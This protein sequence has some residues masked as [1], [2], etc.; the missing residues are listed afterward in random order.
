MGAFPT[1]VAPP[2]FSLSAQ[3]S[4]RIRIR[5]REMI[6]ALTST[7]APFATALEPS[8]WVYHVNPGNDTVF[9]W[10]S[11]VSLA[12][13]KYRVNDLSVE[14]I[15][16][17]AVT[18]SNTIMISPEYDVNDPPATSIIRAAPN[19]D[20]VQGAT[21]SALRCHFS[22]IDHRRLYF[23]RGGTELT[24]QDPKEY[25][26][27]NFTIMYAGANGF[28][29]YVYI[30]YDIELMI[31]NNDL[32][33]SGVCTLTAGGVP[34]V[35]PA[36]MGFG[37]ILKDALPGILSVVGASPCHVHHLPKALNIVSANTIAAE[38][39]C[40]VQDLGAIGAFGHVWQVVPSLR[41]AAEMVFS[42]AA[43]ALGNQLSVYDLDMHSWL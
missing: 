43:G 5:H 18:T 10:L 14:Y 31:P 28:V 17:Q 11:R 24:G 15:P 39:G 19:Q 37:S 4:N 42:V 7:I 30:N 20:T 3:S 13:D 32:D 12:Y 1:G 2:N 33:A 29:G 27:A 36:A 34:T 35:P 23:T 16:G 8:T 6:G 25:D 41:G 26:C 9:P 21:H 22:G 38:L 40:V